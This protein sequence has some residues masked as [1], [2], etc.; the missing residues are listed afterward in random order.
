MVH[1]RYGLVSLGT[2]FSEYGVEELLWHLL[3]I[4]VVGDLMKITVCSGLM[5]QFVHQFPSEGAC[6]LFRT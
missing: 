2:Y 3:D 6:Q 5:T 4:Q 1:R